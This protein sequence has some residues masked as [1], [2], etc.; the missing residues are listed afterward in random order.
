MR[1][2]YYLHTPEDHVG[3]VK[4]Y[5]PYFTNN[6]QESNPMGL[7]VQNERRRRRRDDT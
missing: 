2:I 3:K 7:S 1:C 6:K 4:A 5:F